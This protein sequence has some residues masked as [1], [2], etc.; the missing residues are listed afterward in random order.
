MQG[1]YRKRG[2]R[3]QAEIQINKRRR[4]RSFTTKKE[5]QKWVAEL[6]AIDRGEVPSNVTFS[7]AYQKYQESPDS[8]KH[9]TSVHAMQKF[10][11][12]VATMLLQDF[13]TK[14][15]N[16]W[17]SHMKGTL[18]PGTVR[19]YF[20]TV[21]GVFMRAKQ[22]SLIDKIPWDKDLLRLPESS[23][24]RD[25]RITEDELSL[26][27]TDADYVAAEPLVSTRQM[28]CWCMDFAIETAMRG[29][30][31]LQTRW[32]NVHPTFVHL[33]ADITKTSKARDV[34]LSRTART[35]VTTARQSTNSQ[36][37]MPVQSTTMK[38]C[39]ERMCN[40]VGIEDLVFHDTRHEATTRLAKKLHVLDLAR[41]TGH[42]N[43]NELMTYYNKDARELADLL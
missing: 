15:M 24:G 3:W 14:F 28:V 7:D 39:F 19:K 34:P 2:D 32:D 26:F 18:K 12:G 30:E 9:V 10:D 20:Y 22:L 35:L 13:D 1:T 31:I 25:R 8:L 11:L 17:I 5:A 40:K 33:P 37:L 36:M 21:Q 43:L 6:V 27:Y 29:G 16:A 38:R 23:P 4:S 41:V 42:S